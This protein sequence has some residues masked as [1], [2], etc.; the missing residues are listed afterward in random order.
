M[1]DSINN[2]VQKF[3]IPLKGAGANV[4]DIFKKISTMIEFAC[5]YMAVHTLQY[6]SVWWRLF[7]S[8][9]K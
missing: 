5:D 7:N 2:L 3:K 4:D 8:P 1:M 9:Q 6:Q